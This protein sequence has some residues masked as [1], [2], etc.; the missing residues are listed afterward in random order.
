MK[1]HI[2]II[3]LMSFMTLTLHAMEGDLQTKPSRKHKN[4]HYNGVHKKSHK[5][6]KKR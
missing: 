6:I 1:N 5:L 2:R 4:S 3:A